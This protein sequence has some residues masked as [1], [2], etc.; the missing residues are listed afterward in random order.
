MR[1]FVLVKSNTLIENH[2]AKIKLFIERH[3]SRT[4]DMEELANL[5]HLSQGHI[6]RLF[7]ETYNISP[8]QYHSLI[9][10]QKAKSM[11]RN[12]NMSITEIADRLGFSSVQDFCRVFKKVDGCVPSTYRSTK[13]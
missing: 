5:T 9:R 11:I 12:T 6:F 3:V 2:A 1:Y 13:L 8:L 7:R 4:I 10:I